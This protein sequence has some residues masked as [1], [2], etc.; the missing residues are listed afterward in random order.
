MKNLSWCVF[1]FCIALFACSKE[2]EE[3]NPETP[4]IPEDPIT[5][6]CDNPATFIFEEKEGLI[7]IEMENSDYPSE[8]TLET[9]A[10]TAMNYL[11]WEGNNF[12]N[13]PGNG[14][15]IFK[16]QIT[17]P[18]KYR[19]VWNSA[20]TLGDDGTEHND[21]WLRFSDASD[22]Y[23]E[24]NDSRV[25]PNGSGNEPN[26]NGSSADGW[27]KIYRSGSDLDFKWQAKTS[28]NDSHDIYVEF[29][30]E[31]IYTME[32][33]GRSTAHAIDK[34]VLYNESSLT[35]EDAISGELAE[36]SCTND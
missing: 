30:N 27:F 18:G 33:S 26:P 34:I 1:V 36:I 14:L 25:Y 31:G 10:S 2:E 13:A 17:N 6:V 3:E 9:D 5:V 35:L 21:S 20:V 23:G 7:A 4:T 8:W 16:I 28:D 32:I 24:K 15:I 11:V 29:D 19:F 12:F 22:F